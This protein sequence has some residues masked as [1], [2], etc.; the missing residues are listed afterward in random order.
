MSA[1]SFFHAVVYLSLFF[2]VQE[3]PRH[4]LDAERFAEGDNGVNSK[5]GITRTT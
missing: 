4:R 5:S 3:H 1:D 2:L